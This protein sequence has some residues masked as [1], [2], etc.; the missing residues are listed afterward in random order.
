M[1]VN[2]INAGGVSKKIKVGFSWTT[3]FFGFLP[4]LFRGDLKWAVI[5]LL[6]EI[7]VGS[8]SFG[9]GVS[10]VTIIFSFIYNK[11]NIKDLIERG[12]KPA[13]ENDRDLLVRQ[14][15]IS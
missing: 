13:S 10:I 11:I 5:I 8:F 12:Y 14:G 3:L 1:K 2:L 4:A 15:I 6:I 9:I 7:L